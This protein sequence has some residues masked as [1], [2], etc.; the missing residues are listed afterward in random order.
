MWRPDL[1][2]YLAVVSHRRPDNV[3]SMRNQI[4]LATWYVKDETDAALYQTRHLVNC[5][6]RLGHTAS[7]PDQRNCALDDAFAHDLPCLLLDDDLQQ[8]RWWS[9][10]DQGVL[11]LSPCTF[12]D[13]ARYLV[14]TAQVLPDI[15]LF[16][17]GSMTNGM[18]VGSAGAITLVG[19]FTGNVV[20][21]MPNPLRYDP[22]FLVKEDYEYT[23]QHLSTYGCVARCNHVVP[24]F[25]WKVNAGGCQTYRGAGD[26]EL[27]NRRLAAKWPGVYVPHG[28]KWRLAWPKPEISVALKQILR[29]PSL[30]RIEGDGH[31][32]G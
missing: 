26:E 7:L 12:A 11:K 4:G 30:W 21:V 32:S 14:S 3:T 9:R 19:F 18:Y 28:D 23:L 20:L 10:D 27:W 8:C 25:L 24:R 17:A 13:T 16:G 29:D 1:D 6:A 2:V 31:V 22:A 5:T 15:R